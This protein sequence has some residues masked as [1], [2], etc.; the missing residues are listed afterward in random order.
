L[1]DCNWLHVDKPG[2]AFLIIDGAYASSQTLGG[3]L[4][5]HRLQLG[6]GRS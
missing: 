2:R 4:P 3:R 6:A 5:T 1:A